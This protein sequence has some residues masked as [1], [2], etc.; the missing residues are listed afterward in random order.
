MKL[1]GK[2]RVQAL[3]ILKPGFQVLTICEN[4]YGK[5]TEI[6]EYRRTNRGGK[7]VINIDASDRNGP[8]VTSLA[9]KDGD[10][11]VCVT[12]KGMIIRSPVQEIRSTGRNAQGV[13]IITLDEG[14]KIVSVDRLSPEDLEA[15]EPPPPT[16]APAGVMTA[17]KLP[18]PAAE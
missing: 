9:V 4:G 13:R 3:D 17:P 6:D 2:D 14:D 10:E 15:A 7:G 16:A 11:I 12:E 18:A 1:S 8:V 5:R